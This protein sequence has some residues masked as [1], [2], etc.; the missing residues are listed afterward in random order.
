MVGWAWWLV[1]AGG[2][3]GDAVR[4]PAAALFEWRCCCRWPCRPTSQRPTPTDFLQFSGR[5]RPAAPPDR[6][7]GRCIPDVRSLWRRGLLFIVLPLP[8]RLPAGAHRFRANAPPLMEAARLLGAGTLRRRARGGAAAGAPGGGRRRRAGADGDAGRLR[9]RAYFGINHLHRRHLQGLAGDGQ[10]RSPP[11]SSA[12]RCCWLLV[13]LLL[14][15]E[16]RAARLRFA[17]GH[18]RRRDA[19]GRG[20]PIELAAPRRA[21][22]G[23]C[24]C[25]C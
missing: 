6:L 5:C 17:S 13:A 21:G 20:R 2:G 12:S 15:L 14:G 19:C 25:R 23:A 11:R 10:P 18:A 16:Q 9:R 24:R 3:A 7:E 8:L 22:G 1:G 4:V